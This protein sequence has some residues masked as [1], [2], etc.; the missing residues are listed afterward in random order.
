MYEEFTTFISKLINI[1]MCLKKDFILE[2]IDKFDVPIKKLNYPDNHL[3]NLSI[4]LKFYKNFNLDY[5]NIIHQGISNEAIFIFSKSGLDSFVDTKNCQTRIQLMN[6]DGDVITIVHEL[7]HYIDRILTPHI[8]FDKY[9][10]LGETF[11][12]YFERELER[13]LGP[14]YKY[15]FDIRKNNRLYKEKNMLQ[16]IK[17]VLDYENDYLKNGKLKLTEED[18]K[19][20]KKII[21][22]GQ[23]DLI[24]F[25][26]SYPIANITSLYLVNYNSIIT[27]ENFCELCLSYDIK[28]F[29]ENHCHLIGLDEYKQQNAIVK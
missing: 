24:N 21:N 4:A 12:F 22:L 28:E 15:L 13:F 9:W 27:K 11:A 8:V 1:K 20:I 2:L 14:Q 19:N 26:L 5:Y 23:D 29:F 10:F 16:I 3:D 18:A 17:L 25:C 6:N 7:A